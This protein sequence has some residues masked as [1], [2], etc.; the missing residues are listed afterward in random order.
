[1]D[2]LDE[3]TLY[4]SSAV[5]A[6]PSAEHVLLHGRIDDEIVDALGSLPEHYRRAV[7]LCDVQGLSYAEIAQQMGCA[8]G[9][10]MSRLHR[11][12]ALLRQ[13]LMELHSRSNVHSR[14]TAPVTVP[15]RTVQPV[16]V[17]A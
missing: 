17:A 2:N 1:M 9:T 16:T 12:R 4:G 14:S 10:V 3:N 7:L 6:S 15:T 8:L 11:G 5:S 13:A